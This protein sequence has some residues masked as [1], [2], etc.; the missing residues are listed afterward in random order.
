MFMLYSDLKLPQSIHQHS[1]QWPLSICMSNSALSAQ[2]N[3]AHTYM[4]KRDLES[5]EGMFS[6]VRLK[7]NHFLKFTA[8]NKTQGF[9][10][11]KQKLWTQWRDQQWGEWESPAPAPR[12]LASSLCAFRSW[13]NL[14]V[15]ATFGP[16]HLAGI[17]GH[18]M[19][20]QTR[21]QMMRRKKYMW[22]SSSVAKAL[23]LELRL[24]A[25]R[26]DLGLAYERSCKFFSALQLAFNCCSLGGRG[27]VCKP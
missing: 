18:K 13:Q 9:F 20:T 22:K 8:L 10:C 7:T 24:W 23:G 17:L 5:S 21:N 4:M 12:V 25:G 27:G 3:I 14:Y 11:Q 6:F 15:R 1:V 16:Q 26:F 2:V 19:N